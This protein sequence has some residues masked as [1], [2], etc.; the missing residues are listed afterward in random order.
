MSGCLVGLDAGVLKKVLN[1]F[2]IPLG[3]YD[4]FFLFKGPF[5]TF[6]IVESEI[7]LNLHKQ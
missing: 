2:N 6:F 4:N 3:L 5:P 1:F 7:S